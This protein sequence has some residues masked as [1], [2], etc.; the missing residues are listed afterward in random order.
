MTYDEY[1]QSDIWKAKRSERLRIDGYRCQMCGTAKNL[2]VHH[3]RYPDVLGMESVEDLVT[4]CDRCHEHAHSAEG[5]VQGRRA[6]MAEIRRNIRNASRTVWDFAFIGFALNRCEALS[7]DPM[8]WADLR[9]VRTE[10]CKIFGKPEDEIT[11]VGVQ[12]FQTNWEHAEIERFLNSGCNS[13]SE[14]S[15]K[16]GIPQKR[17]RKH[18]N[19]LKQLGD[20]MKIMNWTEVEP[21][22]TG[23]EKLPAGAYVLRIT[24]VSGHTSKAG[25]PYLTFTYDVAEGEH[26]G[27][28]ASETRDYVHSFNRS[29]T[30]N[31]AP[32]FRALLDA[33]EQ[34]NANFDVETWQRTCDEQAFVG[35]LVGVLFRDKIRTNS[36]GK[37][38]T[39]LDYVRPM[40]AAEVR[41]G[42]W[43]VPPVKDEREEGAYSAGGGAPASGGFYSYGQEQQQP[44]Q[45]ADP[46]EADVPF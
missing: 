45:P 31:S 27:H 28:Y 6:E 11:L 22:G 44:Q 19:R 36:K 26:A 24:G 32:F 7:L 17:I 40:A 3:I 15:K 39:V 25:N 46:Y 33:F 42:D 37:D 5:L 10:F 18:V 12:K 29:Y 41:G 34:S 16:T 1:I 38:V 9:I 8:K 21:A 20:K 13:I 30:G 4:L 43:T 14:I 2:R 23:A 35:L